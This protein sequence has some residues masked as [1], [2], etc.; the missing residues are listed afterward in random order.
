M[1]VKYFITLAALTFVFAFSNASF[2]QAQETGTE[3][4]Q[5]QPTPLIT[6]NPFIYNGV[7]GMSGIFTYRTLNDA[8]DIEIIDINTAETKLVIPAQIDGHKVKKVNLETLTSDGQLLD[9]K[10]NSVSK[11]HVRELVISDG[12]EEIC[13]HSFMEFANLEK[14]TLAK[15]LHIGRAVFGT[16]S[17]KELTFNGG[18]IGSYNFTS[19]TLEQ[20][21]IE[22]EFYGAAQ[23]FSDCKIKKVIVDAPYADVGGLFD[24]TKV[25]EMHVSKRV[26]R[27]TFVEDY[28][29]DRN[30]LDKLYIKGKK[31]RLVFD[32]DVSELP[33][34]NVNIGTVYLESG[35][36]G[37]ADVKDEKLTYQVK[38]TG[39][40]TTYTAKKQGSK[41]RATWKK[42]KTTIQTNK[43][44]KSKKK[45]SK[46]T[47]NAK[48]MYQV[49]GRMK[50][51]GKFKLIKTTAQRRITSKYKYIRVVPVKSW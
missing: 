21:K 49:Y 31:T 50:K 45:W 12:V 17:V 48:T 22:G 40:A 10:A 25:N 39:K 30:Q 1:K 26:K 36:K 44:N 5:A 11:Y 27:L 38:K 19:C 35:A 2:A 46:K 9:L 7:K 18:G 16:C 47:K 42:I 13:D 20:V 8:G 51:S 33:G 41:Y 34:L 6:P 32:S 23:T 3:T 24:D 37:I 14:I 28:D 4:E 43:Y 29:I 15:N